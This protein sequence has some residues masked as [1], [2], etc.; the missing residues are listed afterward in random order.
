MALW[1]EIVVFWFGVGIFLA[2]LNKLFWDRVAAPKRPPS[3]PMPSNLKGI[4]QQ[5]GESNAE[6][7]DSQR[8]VGITGGWENGAPGDV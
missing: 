7:Y 4:D 3:Q 5:H 6:S 2:C 1:L 8:R